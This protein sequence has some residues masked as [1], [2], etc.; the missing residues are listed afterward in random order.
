M[1]ESIEWW[2]WVVLFVILG[3]LFGVWYYLNRANLNLKNILQKKNTR[4]TII[5]R[6]WVDSRTTVTLLRIDNTDYLLA[7]NANGLGWQKLEQSDNLTQTTN[8][9]SP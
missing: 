4:L 5:E 3:G 1:P 6:C 8:N 7:H 9:K 2:R